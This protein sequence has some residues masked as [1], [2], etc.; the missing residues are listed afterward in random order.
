MH[1]VPGNDLKT[2]LLHRTAFLCVSRF[3]RLA[4]FGIINALMIAVSV[5]FLP[6]L[7]VIPKFFVSLHR[8]SKCKLAIGT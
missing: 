3:L 8:T 4:S 6:L 5:T 2:V 7:S 1:P